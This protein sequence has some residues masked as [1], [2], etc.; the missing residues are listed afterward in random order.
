MP[1]HP[2]RLPSLPYSCSHTGPQDKKRGSCAVPDLQQLLMVSAIRGAPRLPTI[3]LA[4]RL[5]PPTVVSFVATKLTNRKSPPLFLP[6][7]MCLLN[8]RRVH[9]SDAWAPSHSGG[10]HTRTHT[11][12]TALTCLSFYIR[13]VGD[14]EAGEEMIGLKILQSS[15]EYWDFC[16]QVQCKVI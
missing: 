10:M 6:A 4:Q 11:P 12:V 1:P 2:R 5:A 3:H 15:T 8:T 16:A 7:F 14:E 9:D 13:N